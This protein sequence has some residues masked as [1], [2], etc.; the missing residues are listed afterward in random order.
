MAETWTVSPV[1]QEDLTLDTAGGGTPGTQ[2]ITTS[3]GGTQSVTKLSAATFPVLDAAVVTSARTPFAAISPASDRDIEEC[4]RRVRIN[5]REAKNIEHYGAVAGT[6]IADADAERNT[7]AWRKCLDDISSDGRNNGIFFPGAR[8]EFKDLSGGSGLYGTTILPFETSG[9]VKMSNVMVLGA[10]ATQIVAHA[11]STVSKPLFYA[12]GSSGLFFVD[13]AITHRTGAT[14]Q[15]VNLDPLTNGIM[16]TFRFDGVTFATG[17]E[18]VRTEYASGSNYVKDLWITNCIMNAAGSYSLVLEDVAGMKLTGN[19]FAGAN[20]GIN[21]TAEGTVAWGNY[22]IF[23]NSLVNGSIAQGITISTGGATFTPTIHNTVILR[24][25]KMSFGTISISDVNNLTIEGNTLFN[26]V[27]DVNYS[28][29]PASVY[30][31]RINR[32]TVTGSATTLLFSAIRVSCASTNMRRWWINEN[33][34]Y[35]SGRHGIHISPTGNGRL[36]GGEI[37]RNM[38]LDPSQQTTNTYDG[39]LL[40]SAGATSGSSETMVT[41]N[42]VTST[43]ASFKMRRGV[44]ETSGAVNDFNHFLSNMV[45]GWG[46]SA[47]SALGTNSTDKT[48]TGDG[49]TTIDLET[50]V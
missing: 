34:I 2:T 39:I 8:Y 36:R 14:A 22:E 30:D 31:M 33:D 35:L 20:L 18:H 43:N 1:G 6:S 17:I 5:A 23:N 38:I 45:K 11:N 29:D 40:D 41:N 9:A 42:R 50:G 13:V 7:Q 19:V 25:N 4:L 21:L 10:P 48:N 15:C 27:I 32:N 46:T 49:S 28:S 26:G 47:I 16:S 3:T 24:D 37:A 44:G 12:T